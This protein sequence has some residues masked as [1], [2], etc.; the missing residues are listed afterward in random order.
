MRTLIRI[1]TAAILAGGILSAQTAKPAD[2]WAGLDFLAGDWVGV[3]SGAP[4]PTE[5][6]ASFAFQLDRRILV[7]KSWA[8]YPSRSG[9]SARVRHED[10][11]VIYPAAGGTFR[12]IYFDNEGHTIEYALVFPR[13]GSVVFESA[14]SAPGPRYRLTYELGADGILDNAFAVAA[15]GEDYKTYVTGRLKK[16]AVAAR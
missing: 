16:K 15:P 9:G 4:G 2:P 5:G 3:G 7:R 13:A 6:G 11:I 14:A 10:L 8:E 12:A 1:A